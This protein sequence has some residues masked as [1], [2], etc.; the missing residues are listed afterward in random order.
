VRWIALATLLLAGCP[1]SDRGTPETDPLTL[2][3][4]AELR[5]VTESMCACSNPT[6]ARQVDDRFAHWNANADRSNLRGQLDGISES[7]RLER[8][9]AKCRS[10]AL[11]R[12]EPE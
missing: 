2:D 3:L 1:N 4:L 9:L 8:R 11:A 10:E 6:C 5:A 12:P 7:K